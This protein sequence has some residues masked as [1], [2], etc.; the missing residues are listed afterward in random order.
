M[1]KFGK[2]TSI[3]LVIVT[4][5][6]TTFLPGVPVAAWS[7]SST[8][9]TP[10]CTAA[11]LQQDPQ[12]VSDGSGGAII[13][14]FDYRKGSGDDFD[15]Y[16]QRVD[17]SG[18]A[19]WSDNGTAI[20]TAPN[21][22]YEPQLVSDG[23]GGAIITWS[24]YRSGSNL[25]IYAQRVDA[26]GNALW[27]DNGTA[28]CT[29]ANHQEYPYIVSDGSGGAIIAWRDYRSGSG[30]EDIYAQ[31]V[32]ASGSTLWTDNGTAICNAAN[33]QDVPKIVVDGSGGAIIV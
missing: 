12:I 30:N 33:T 29:A 20:C 6:L 32:D 23:S 16:A 21:Q 4:I 19:L 25:D 22:T 17:A 1:I 14:W 13:V 2:S 18:S 9:N 10:V 11:N 7:T 28:I 24:D 15:I 26:S 3:L 5:L 8:A 31:R 27:T